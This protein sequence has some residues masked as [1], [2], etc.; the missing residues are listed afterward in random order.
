MGGMVTLLIGDT[1]PF[2]LIFPLTNTR[3]MQTRIH[4]IFDINLSTIDLSN[5]IADIFV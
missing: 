5:G 3:A 1:L 4:H 2:S